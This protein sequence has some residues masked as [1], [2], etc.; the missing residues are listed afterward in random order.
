MNS[1]FVWCFESLN[2][3]DYSWYSYAL[4]ELLDIYSFYNWLGWAT[5]LLALVFAL[6]FY[7]LPASKL[8]G[9]TK[10]IVSLFVLFGSSLLVIRVISWKLYSMMIGSTPETSELLEKVIDSVVI[11][12]WGVGFCGAFWCIVFYIVFS[13]IMMNFS[14]HNWRVPFK[15]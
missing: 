9:R 11:D 3:S 7:L 14:T 1:F 4:A 10:W 13:M 6:L 5:V 12:L 8:H 2:G 15:K